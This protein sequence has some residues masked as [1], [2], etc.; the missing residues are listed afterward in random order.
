MFPPDISR[1]PLMKKLKQHA[2]KWREIGTYL[3]FL[4]G[5]LTNIEARPYLSQSAPTSWLGAMLEERIQYGLQGIIE[6]APALPI[7][8]I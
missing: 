7:C 3:G 5:E 2:A 1:A 8:K 4:P 6:E